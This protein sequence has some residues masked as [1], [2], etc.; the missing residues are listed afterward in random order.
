MNN[1]MEGVA[2]LLGVELE[3]VF[4]LKEYES[5]FKF[6][7]KDFES[8]VN[9]TTWLA[10]DS[11]TLRFILEGKVTIKKL[12]WKPKNGEIY[13]YSC[14]DYDYL[15]SNSIWCDDSLDRYRFKYNMVFKTK[16]EAIALGQKMLTLA[17]ENN[18]Q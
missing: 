10:G 8:S 3:E 17:K 16:E 6:T 5:Y 2:K 18:E 12:P 9:G 11:L 13:Y 7:E 15:C 1:Y 4:R 14:P